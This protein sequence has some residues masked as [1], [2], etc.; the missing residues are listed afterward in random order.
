MALSTFPSTLTVLIAVIGKS[1]IFLTAIP[2]TC[3]TMELLP[4]NLAGKTGCLFILPP[5]SSAPLTSLLAKI[6][7]FLPKNPKKRLTFCPFPEE[8]IGGEEI[9]WKTKESSPYFSS[10]R[11][12]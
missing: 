10:A 3:R 6:A 11:G 1:H 4:F 2:R 9:R 8:Q 7:S 5:S 12:S